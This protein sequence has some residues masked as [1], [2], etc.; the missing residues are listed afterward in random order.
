MP[1]REFD[2]EKHHGQMTVRQAGE[3]VRQLIEA[4]KVKEQEEKKEQEKK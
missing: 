4:G 1:R 2:K 3:R